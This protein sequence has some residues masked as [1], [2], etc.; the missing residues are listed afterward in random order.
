MYRLYSFTNYYLSSIQKG[1]QTAHVIADMLVYH[2]TL[3]LIDWVNFYKTIIVLNGGNS[4]AL[5]DIASMLIKPE[6]RFAWG[7]FREDFDS[8]AG[9]TTAVGVLVPEPFVPTTDFETRL[10]ELIARCPLAV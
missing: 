5:E 3:D 8:L 2:E 6:N 10:A 4:A 7:I 9:A 1:I